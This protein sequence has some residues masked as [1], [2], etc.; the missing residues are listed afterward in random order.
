M[1]CECVDSEGNGERYKLLNMLEPLLLLFWIG[2][3]IACLGASV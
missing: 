1:T 2:F 3:L